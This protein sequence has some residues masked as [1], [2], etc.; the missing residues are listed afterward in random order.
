MPLQTFANCSI[1]SGVMPVA[2]YSTNRALSDVYL[3]LLWIA[4]CDVD[5]CILPSLC[6]LC[7]MLRQWRVTTSVFPCGL[8]VCK[9]SCRLLFSERR[10]RD[11]KGSAFSPLLDW[12]VVFSFCDWLNGLLVRFLFACSHKFS[13]PEKLDWLG[14]FSFCD[15]LNGFTVK[16]TLITCSHDFF[17]PSK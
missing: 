1:Y 9:L 13:D 10:G 6:F 14:V 15:W 16:F 3:V 4:E 7:M 5:N 11:N 2:N 12:L 17:Q 8:A